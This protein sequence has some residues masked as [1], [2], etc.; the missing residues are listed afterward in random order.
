MNADPTTDRRCHWPARLR[1]GALRFARASN[2]YAD[3][4]A[5]YRDLVGLPVLGEFVDS[6]DAEGTIFGLPDASVQLEIVRARHEDEAD[7]GGGA[8]QLVLYLDNAMELSAGTSRLRAAGLLPDLQPH[9]YWAANGAVTYRD[10]DGR[11]M[12]FAPWV[13]GRDIDPVA[14]LVSSS[15]K[16]VSA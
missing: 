14:R 2:N 6:F 12:I 5:F 1:P 16:G 15:T 10:P 4:I 7:N 9:A 11:A 13:F 3:T 8:D